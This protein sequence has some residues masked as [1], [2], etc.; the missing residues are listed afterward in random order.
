MSVSVKPASCSLPRVLRGCPGCR[1]R[2]CTRSRCAGA[3]SAPGPRTSGRGRGTPQRR[4]DRARTAAVPHRA[5]RSTRRSAS[6]M[7]SA[8]L[9]A[10]RG[11]ITETMNPAGVRHRDQ[12]DG[13]VHRSDH[14]E[15]RRGDDRV[16]EHAHPGDLLDPRESGGEAGTR[17]GDGSAASETAAPRLP[18]RPPPPVA[19]ARLPACSPSSTVSSATGRDVSIA[20][21]DLLDH[22]IRAVALQRLD[23]DVDL[24]A[25]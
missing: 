2:R 25:A 3:L 19:A 24:A 14:H 13:D 18:T 8:L 9:K 15:L 23:E 20:R 11:S 5:M 4:A 22:R 7:R 6:V 10:V 16:D 17:C 1:S 21:A 12:G